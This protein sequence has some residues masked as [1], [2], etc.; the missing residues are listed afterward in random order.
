MARRPR[1][2]SASA[3]RVP[4]TSAA[5]P[6]P[7][8][9]PA[10]GAEGPATRADR[11]VLVGVVLLAVAVYANSAVN[12]F[13]LD[14][15]SLAIGNPFLHELRTIPQLFTVDY[16]YPETKSGLYR[17]VVTTS[18]ALNFAAGGEDPRGYHLVNIALHA[19]NSAL[20]LLLFRRATADRLAIAAGAALFAAHA[21]HSEAVANVSG[22]AE[23]LCAFFFLASLLLYLESWRA[24]ARWTVALYAASVLAYLLAL[25]SKETALTLV[26]VVVLHDFVYVREPEPRLLRRAALVL[27]CGALRYAGYLLSTVAYLALRYLWLDLGDPRAGTTHLDNPLLF[28]EAPWRQ[29]SALEVAL[30]YLWLLLFPARLSYDYSFDQIPL[31]TSPDD[32]R[33]LLVAA[34]LALGAGLAVASYRRAVDLFFALGLGLVT[35]SVISNLVIGIGTIMAERLL[36]LPSLGFCLA[37]PLAARWLLRRSRPGPWGD[38]IFV[39]IFAV[40]VALHGERA[41]VRNR[42]WVSDERLLLGD[43]EVSPRSAKVRANAGSVLLSAGRFEEAVERYEASLAI[44]PD[45]AKAAAQ[46]GHALLKL[47]RE[48]EAMGRYEQAVRAKTA[49]AEAWNNLGFLL[50]DRG[51][52]VDRGLTLIQVAVKLEPKNPS[53]LDSLGWAYFKQGRLEEARRWVQRSLELDASGESGATRQAHLEEIERALRSRGPGSGG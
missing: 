2:R 5:A 48:E 52:G 1:G 12:G 29:L 51:I 28:V 33:I 21:V 27:R 22:R 53:F 13:T 14:D 25:L 10:T 6:R 20:V 36:Y 11:L 37:A 31:V 46:L 15:T 40:A 41:L 47:G 30:R 9:V 24:S 38:R 50:V 49:N 44:K 32:P 3:G 43:L 39:A 23:L 7:W 4:P 34:V 42:D 16:W 45:Y 19:A 26:G 17:P 35:F 8:S 18:F